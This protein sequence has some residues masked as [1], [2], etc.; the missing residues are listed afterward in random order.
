MGDGVIL[1]DDGSSQVHHLSPSASIVWRL[2]RGEADVGQ[3]AADIAEAY[4]LDPAESQA[5]L[6]ATIAEVEALGLGEGDKHIV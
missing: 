4:G 6:T 5:Q 3:L 1:Y 2:C